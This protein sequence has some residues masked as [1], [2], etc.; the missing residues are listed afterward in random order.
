MIYIQPTLRSS[1]LF[2]TLENVTSFNTG[3]V[4]RYTLYLP[5]LP[6]I[7]CWSDAGEPPTVHG[8][9]NLVVLRQVDTEPQ[10]AEGAWSQLAQ[11]EV[12]ALA[13]GTA[14]RQSATL[15]CELWRGPEWEAGSFK[16]C[17]GRGRR[18]GGGLSACLT[19]K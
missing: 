18:G 1:Y 6:Q 2:L 10:A 9:L 5:K 8:D 17:S 12:Q 15:R 4:R 7:V 3:S 16:Y 13:D 11:L 19:V 14:A